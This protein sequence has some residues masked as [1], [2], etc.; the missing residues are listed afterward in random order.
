MSSESSDA[1]REQLFSIS[2]VTIDTI[3]QVIDSLPN[4]ATKGFDGISIVILKKSSIAVIKALQKIF[5][6]SVSVGIFPSAWKQ[7]IVTLI[8]KKEDI[9]DL[10]NY[11]SIFS[12]P[13]ISKV[14]ENLVIYQLGDYLDSEGIIHNSQHGFR[15]STHARLQLTQTL[16][17]SHIAKNYRACNTINT[18]IL[19][20]RIKSFT[21]T[22]P[23]I[24][25][26][27]Y[28]EGRRQSVKYANAF[29]NPID[30]KSDVPQGSIVA[31]VLFKIYINDLLQ[32][33]Q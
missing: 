4:S 24:R 7:V 20:Q 19:N 10:N 5:N 33:L 25:F 13:V 23:S 11:Y 32:N 30:M 9:F 12:Q 6:T 2:P 16:F 8:Q 29:S 22:T 31:P 1:K 14:F 3:Q 26:K 15:K 21:T 27:S 18:Y 17:T 28:I